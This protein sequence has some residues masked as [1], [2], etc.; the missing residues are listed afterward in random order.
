[1]QWISKVSFRYA[2]CLTFV[3]H[4]L[5]V[6]SAVPHRSNSWCLFF[7]LVWFGLAWFGLVWLGLAWF[8]LVWLGL[9]WFG[10]V[11]LGLV[12][13]GL[14]GGCCTNRFFDEHYAL[15]LGIIS[16][17]CTIVLAAWPLSYQCRRKRRRRRTPSHGL[18]HQKDLTTT[19]HSREDCRLTG[20]DS[21]STFV[22]MATTSDG[23]RVEDGWR[24][25]THSTATTAS[26]STP[27]LLDVTTH[28][29]VATGGY[30]GV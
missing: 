29:M 6:Y 9:A 28:P 2:A 14:V 8:G 19:N 25:T 13:F 23:S 10:L 18:D 26:E 30:M 4:V 12:W 24:T 5:S 15:S 16:I 20:A 3:V 17:L 22:S 27:L 1:M 7:G 11:W 21:P